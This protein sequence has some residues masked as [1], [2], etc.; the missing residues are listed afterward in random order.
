MNSKTLVLLR[1]ASGM[2]SDTIE[3]RSRIGL[4]NPAFPLMSSE[5]RDRTKQIQKQEVLHP[6]SVQVVEFIGRII[7]KH[8]A[9]N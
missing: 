2:I 9:L 1:M 3:T 7:L 8:R 5:G 4:K 6:W